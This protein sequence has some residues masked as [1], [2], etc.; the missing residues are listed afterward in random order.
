MRISLTR[1]VAFHALHHYQHPDRSEPEHHRHSGQDTTRPHGH[2]YRIEIT[3]SGTPDPATS[4]LL[5]LDSLDQLINQRITRLLAGT[6]LN[7][8]IESIRTGR[9]QPSCEGL[10]GWCWDQID[11]SLPDGVILERVRVAEDQTLWAECN[12]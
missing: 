8:S 10:A 3:V 4:T 6:D 2:L 5:D 11:G 12:R 7:Q 9:L 1:A